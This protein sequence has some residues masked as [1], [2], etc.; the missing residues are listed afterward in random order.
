MAAG[1]GFGVS[2]EHLFSKR[3]NM[4]LLQQLF[5]DVAVRLFISLLTETV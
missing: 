3:L 1:L 2:A 4:R 5:V